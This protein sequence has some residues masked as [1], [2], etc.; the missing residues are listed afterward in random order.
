[1]G[2]IVSL[3]EKAEKVYDEE[4]AKRLEEKIRKSEFTLQDFLEQLEQMSKMGSFESLLEM[5]PGMKNQM[6][7]V[8]I[9]EK[10]IKKQK[11]IIQSMTIKERTDHRLVMGSRKRRIAKGAGVSVLDVDNL[12]K[13]FQKSRQMM[14]NMVKGKGRIPGFDM[15]F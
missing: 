11:A 15:G 4:E 12:L 5:I 3:V 14:K 1:M 7:N 8:N 13:N 9:D 10:K 2:D 6:Q